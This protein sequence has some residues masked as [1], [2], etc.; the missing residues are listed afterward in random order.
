MIRTVVSIVILFCMALFVQTQEAAAGECSR[1]T[2]QAAVDSYIEAQ[3]AGDLSK[4]LLADRVKGRG[5]SG[6]AFKI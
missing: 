3:K 1:E 2:L 5:A 6:N 4:A